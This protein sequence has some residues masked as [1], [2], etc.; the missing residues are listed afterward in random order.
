TCC[1]SFMEH[2]TGWV[3]RPGLN[4]PAIGTTE[5]GL[6]IDGEPGTRFA[7]SD[8]SVRSNVWVSVKCLRKRLEGLLDGKE[9]KSFAFEL[10]WTM[11][12]LR[13]TRYWGRYTQTWVR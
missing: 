2:G 10:S 11:A 3:T 8:G 13:R 4:N 1:V 6:I 12:M 7:A 5:T 9:V